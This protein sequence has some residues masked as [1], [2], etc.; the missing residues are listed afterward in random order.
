MSQDLS[1]TNVLG[2]TSV[3][4]CPHVSAIPA[5]HAPNLWVGCM[6]VSHEVAAVPGLTGQ[7]LVCLAKH[8]VKS[9]DDLADL[10][11]DELLEIVGPENMAEAV[12]N[13]VIMAA[14]AHWFEG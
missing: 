8:G 11:R 13:K 4:R 6:G 9:L 1:Q 2:V 5:P 14:R 12:A 10:C 3:R 7:H